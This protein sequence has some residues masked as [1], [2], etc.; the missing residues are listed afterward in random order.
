LVFIISSFDHVGHGAPEAFP[1]WLAA[2]VFAAH[3]IRRKRQGESPVARKDFFGI[4]K[5]ARCVWAFPLGVALLERRSMKSRKNAEHTEIAEHA[6]IRRFFRVFRYF[7]MFR[8]PLS[9]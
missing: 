5:E 3:P 6:E 2:A 1:P 4:G 8:V 9:F 7:R